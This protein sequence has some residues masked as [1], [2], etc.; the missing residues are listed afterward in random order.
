MAPRALPDRIDDQQA[1]EIIC[2]VGEHDPRKPGGYCRTR[3]VEP[4]ERAST[5]SR[6]QPLDD[7]ARPD[8]ALTH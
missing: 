2:P 8:L 3:Q 5:R 6:W 1:C 7:D 4:K